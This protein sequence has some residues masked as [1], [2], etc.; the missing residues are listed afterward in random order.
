MHDRNGKVLQNLDNSDL[1]KT[2]MAY[3]TSIFTAVIWNHGSGQKLRYT[4]KITIITAI[5][6]SWLSYSPSHNTP[7]LR[8]SLTVSMAVKS[9]VHVHTEFTDP[10]TAR[11]WG[12]ALT[13]QDRCPGLSMSGRPSTVRRL[14]ACLWL[15]TASSPVIRFTVVCRSTCTQ[16]VWWPVLCHCRAAGLELFAGWTA[17][18]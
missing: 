5:M 16:H 3:N 8:G 15:P 18:M 1:L 13:V 10:L 11:K 7:P 4:A 12:S 17:I 2:E 9:G 6:N 14:L